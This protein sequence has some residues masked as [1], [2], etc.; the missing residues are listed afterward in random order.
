VFAIAMVTCALGFLFV[1]A[2]QL[3]SWRLL[4]HWHESARRGE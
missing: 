3:L 4:R 1:G 2:V